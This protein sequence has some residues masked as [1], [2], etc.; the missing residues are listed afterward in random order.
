M[1]KKTPNGRPRKGLDK[2]DQ[3]VMV[4]LTQAERDRLDK[5]RGTIPAAVYLREKA[6]S[7]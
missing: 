7:Q 4:S 3:M 1:A 2:R 6:L 5:A